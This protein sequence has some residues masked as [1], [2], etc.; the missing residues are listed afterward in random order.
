M[1]LHWLIGSMLLATA[2][3]Q[4]TPM[5]VAISPHFKIYSA[6]SEAALRAQADGLERY[7]TVMHRLTH[8]VDSA[9]VMPLT[10]YI[11]ADNE[12]V[13]RGAGVLGYYEAHAAGP[14]AVVPRK[15]YGLAVADIPRIVLY[16][17]YAHHFLL[18]NFAN[19]YSTWFS[20][21]FAE[22]YATTGIEGST[23]TV[24]KPA[25]LRIRS[26]L[27]DAWPPLD[28]MLVPVR[29]LTLEQVDALYARGW[30]LV[31]YL[32]L[33]KQRAG[34]IDGYLRARDAGQ[35][36]AQAFITGFQT[37]IAGIEKELKDYFSTRQL[38][39]VTLDIPNSAAVFVRPATPGEA[40]VAKL[41][42]RLRLLQSIAGNS[43]SGLSVSSMSVFR[44]NCTRL[45]IDARAAGRKT[46]DDSGLQQ[47]IAEA[48]LL[49][50]EI[51]DAKAA[52]AR[53]L[54][55]D[56]ANGRAHLVV[57]DALLAGVP[58]ADKAA[59]IAA[60][61]QIV[62]ANRAAPDDPMPLIAYYRSFVDRGES[63][64]EIAIQ[65]LQRAQQLAP[66]DGGVR[67]MLARIEIDLKHY[68]IASALLR[69]IAFSP[70]GGADSEQA[71]ALLETLPGKHE[72]PSISVPPPG[73]IAP[74]AAA[75]PVPAEAAATPA[76]RTL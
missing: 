19:V 64:P 75:L 65:G 5:L 29:P 41:T 15:V 6:D 52:A 10:V 18:Q 62:A 25:P 36:E 68:D 73:G 54:A 66:Q 27:K 38:G 22:F 42:P 47:L 60:R 57:A 34:Q 67:L 24:G 2:T 32:T 45:A 11:L 70:H 33:S 49:A 4:A 21:G 46:P 37:P 26:L 3:A 9:S 71:K 61:K 59:T 16:H 17:E 69:P 74:T 30:L 40:A 8:T 7:D 23:A 39:Y 31:H 48:E 55:L 50:G 72:M 44:S 51:G 63:A 43:K 1:R 56:P 58:T 14:F 12:D 13:G 76:T 28:K 35:T 20:E 53:A